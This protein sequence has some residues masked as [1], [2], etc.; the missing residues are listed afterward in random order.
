VAV[1]VAALGPET[2]KLEAQAD[3][4]VQ[5]RRAGEEG[6]GVVEVRKF[7][8]GVGDLEAEVVFVTCERTEE[9]DLGEGVGDREQGEEEQHPLSGA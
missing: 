1:N 8:T 7:V 5:E 6:D 9:E 3:V 4:G 2:R